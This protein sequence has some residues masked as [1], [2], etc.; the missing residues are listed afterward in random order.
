MSLAVARAPSG[1]VQL[2]IS[3]APTSTKACSCGFLFKGF[4]FIC[5]ACFGG[6][7][8]GA[9]AKTDAGPQKARIANAAN[10][11][12]F[13]F[14]RAAMYPWIPFAH[15]T[16]RLSC[17]PTIFARLPFRGYFLPCNPPVCRRREKNQKQTYSGLTITQTK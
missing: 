17:C 9:C 15:R 6:V 4:R 2:A 7:D 11:L 12:L 8:A 16:A 3:P 1:S 13:P 5:G 14:F 10:Q